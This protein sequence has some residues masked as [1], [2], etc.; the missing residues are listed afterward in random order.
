MTEQPP[1]R[2]PVK[3]EDLLRLK[4]AER[5]A[6]NFWNDFDR[7]LRAKQLAALVKKE[8]WWKTPF[9]KL[10]AWTRH[11][12]TAAAAAALAIAVWSNQ[13]PSPTAPETARVATPAPAAP[14]ATQHTPAFAFNQP[15][16]P[17]APSAPREETNPVLRAL[18]TTA[19]HQPASPTAP[20][21][22][23]ND[24]SVDLTRELVAATAQSKATPAEILPVKTAELALV[25]TEPTAE[26][27]ELDPRQERL[28][29][30]ASFS[31]NVSDSRASARSGS[32]SRERITRRLT[33]EALNDS[34]SRL[35]MS[36]DRVLI[37]F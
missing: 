16:Q 32:F 2:P 23:E 6:E 24:E 27:A 7:E 25:E 20:A 21:T 11:S 18:Q 10:P 37:K 17:T 4:R 29:A 15:A 13:S 22:A 8:A 3:L 1:P 35:G 5:P 26:P 9:T 19:R 14:E 12:L 33:S 31:P 36:G 28:V 34:Y 30:L